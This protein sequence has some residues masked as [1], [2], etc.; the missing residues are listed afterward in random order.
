MRVLEGFLGSRQLRCVR[1]VGLAVVVLLAGFVSSAFGQLATG[2]FTGTLTDAQGA[3]MAGANVVIR[4]IDTGVEKSTTSNNVGLYVMLLLPPGT[5]NV[6]ASQ[7]G[8][9][10]VTRQGV[11][12]GVGQTL[13]ID[14][15]MPVAAQQALVTVTTE[16]PVLETEKTQLSQ[17]VT[18]NLVDNLP[19][20]SR[21]WEQFVLLTP[22]VTPDGT[23]GQMSFHGLNGLYNNNSVDGA[24]NNSS[25][26]GTARGRPG[27]DGYVYSGAAIR[28][29]QV[30]SGAFTAELGQ[31]AG[32]L[33]NAVTKSGTNTFHGELF[34]NLRNPIFNALDP[35]AKKNSEAIKKEP[36]KLV[37]QQNQ[38]GF[39]V[40][41]PIAR[42]R[43]FFFANYD[44]YR[45]INPIAV[46]TRQ[47][48]PSI[49]DLACPNPASGL[50]EAQCA[51]A[52]TFVTTEVI[53][54]FPRN[55][56]QD[57]S[58]IKLDYTVDQAN[59]LS[60]VVNNRDWKEPRAGSGSSILGA[61]VTFNQNRFVI[62]NWTTLI[63]VD[64]VNQLR[65][66]W[67]KDLTFRPPANIGGNPGVILPGLFTY[68]SDNGSTRTNERRHQISDNFSFTKGVHTFK[69]GFDWNRI[70]YDAR[71]AANSAGEYRYSSAVALPAIVT[72]AGGCTLNPSFG[73]SAQRANTTFC[74]WLLDLY[75]VDVSDGLTGKHWANYNHA[76]DSSGGTVE[77]APGF[78][79]PQGFVAPDTYI[80]NFYS[81][82]YAWYF[83]D[84]WKARAN[85]TI[86][87]GVRYDLQVFPRPHT[88]NTYT[89][90]LAIYTEKWPSEKKAIQP[91]IGVAW[92][93]ADNTVLRVGGGLY[94]SKSNAST[95]KTFSNGGDN[96]QINCIPSD[97]I[98]PE[99]TPGFT[100]PNIVFDLQDVHPGRPFTSS[101]LSESDQPVAGRGL[102][103][104]KGQNVCPCNT[105][106]MDPTQQ[107]PRAYQAQVAIE[108]ELPGSISAS[109]SY[110]FVRGLHLPYNSDVNVE[111]STATKTYDVVNSSGV[112][113]LTSTVPFFTTRTDTLTGA[114]Y[115]NYSGISQR[116]NGLILTVRK[117]PTSYGLEVVANYTLSKSRDGG[118]AGVLTGGEGFYTTHGFLDPFNRGSTPL[119]PFGEEGFSTND[120]RHRFTSSL[121]W[122]PGF[123]SNVS[124]AFARSVLSGWSISNT[125]TISGGTRYSAL[126]GSSRIQCLEPTGSCPDGSRG[127]L[128]GMTGILISSSG[129]PIGGR[130]A[131]LPRNS[132]TQPKI[133]NFDVRLAKQFAITEG[134][135]FEV[136]AEAFN[137]L[138]TTLV[139]RVFDS[140]FT[141][142]APS[143]TSS[144]CP[145][146]D[147]NNTCMAARSS[148]QNARTTSS[149]LFG[150]RQMQ[151]GLRLSF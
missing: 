102:D 147:H 139:Q 149:N 90:L 118:Q 31:A 146:A 24:N 48:D 93:F 59:T 81:T 106:A 101:T 70:R 37:R 11:Q 17:N 96:P 125:A 99:Y 136:R 73:S 64:K 113:Q 67:G 148:F 79:K 135:A 100:F 69:T 91:R 78:A 87:I 72:D 6:T 111:P 14:V 120:V 8:F 150:A 75:G 104:P 49:N 66:Q 34:W 38:Y 92:N 85:L 54:T 63:G 46:E 65:Y 108:H 4:N 140:A 94:Y 127:L 62:G 88:H 57:V 10:T 131:W 68:G 5:Y 35:V 61:Q 58:L 121:V 26:Y 25:Y 142:V 110:H 134:V 98:S 80:E 22:G 45:K 103:F 77:F 82:E 138:N 89:P 40:G 83:Q 41:G 84:T 126:I 130:A 124:N 141:Y 74:A 42:D 39:A 32:G 117:A 132:F 143:A 29:F 3:A 44:G 86:D 43:L 97:C 1:V 114:I 133:V 145:S 109:A 7:T 107:R 2:A 16:A 55:L 60:V 51:A 116:Y 20:A 71:S 115:T 23:S 53:G 21:R 76:G 30:S 112:T 151:F 129:N 123:G 19:T 15:E 128:G 56:R 13:K 50:S 144:T 95:F 18:E 33:V 47:L 12:L 122:Q 137:I 52:K 27:D 36:I 105:R 119:L 9:A 28:E